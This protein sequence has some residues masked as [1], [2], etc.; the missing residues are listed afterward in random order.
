MSVVLQSNLSKFAEHASAYND[1][2]RLAA[3]PY[4]IHTLLNDQHYFEGLSEP[5]YA[6][7]DLLHACM[8]QIH[9]IYSTTCQNSRA[10]SI[11]AGLVASHAHFTDAD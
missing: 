8:L 5:A 1:G 9:D 11:P 3:G 7:V 4:C 10:S 2:M 6:T